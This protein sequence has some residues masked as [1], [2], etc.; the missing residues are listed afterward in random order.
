MEDLNIIEDGSLR[1]KTR[2]FRDRKDGGAAL[3]RM[4]E[5]FRET[6]AM[7]LAIPA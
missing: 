1:D 4:L 2:V 3:A 7:V 5:A 6:S